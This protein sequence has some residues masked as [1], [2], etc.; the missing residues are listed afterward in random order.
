VSEVEVVFCTDITDAPGQ[1]IPE[2]YRQYHRFMHEAEVFMWALAN[3][4]EEGKMTPEQALEEWEPYQ[5]VWP[6]DDDLLADFDGGFPS[7]DWLMDRAPGPASEDFWRA[8]DEVGV[9]GVFYDESSHP[10]GWPTFEVHG[11][12]V[13]EDVCRALEGRYKVL[14]L[15]QDEYDTSASSDLEWA[16][17]IIERGRREPGVAGGGG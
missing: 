12:G 7:P 5:E 3:A 13:L 14:V 8:A 4:V 11:R 10:G 17:R 1:G 9:P 6:L 16:R 15:D 2:E